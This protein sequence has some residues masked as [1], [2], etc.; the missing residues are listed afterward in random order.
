METLKPKK[1]LSEALGIGDT[2][3]ISKPGILP[4]TKRCYGTFTFIFGL[5]LPV[6]WP[7]PYFVS[8]H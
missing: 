7:I 8:G 4:L 5:W 1:R 6:A 3:E 2:L